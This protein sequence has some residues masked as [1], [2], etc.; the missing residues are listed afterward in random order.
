MRERPVKNFRLHFIRWTEANKN[1][2]EG[3]SLAQFQCYRFIWS[4]H[5]PSFNPNYY[6]HADDILCKKK[7][8]FFYVYV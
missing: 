1:V 2:L 4:P 6:R 7:N 3:F 5:C 8:H